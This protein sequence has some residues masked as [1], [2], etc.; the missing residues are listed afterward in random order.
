MS[1]NTPDQIIAHVALLRAVD[2][3]LA[4][5]ETVRQKRDRLNRLLSEADSPD[6]Q[7]LEGARQRRQGVQSENREEDSRR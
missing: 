3:L 2:G 4:Q 5:A 1:R 7:A 6:R